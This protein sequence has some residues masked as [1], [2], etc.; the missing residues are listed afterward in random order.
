MVSTR[1]LDPDEHVYANWV[2]DLIQQVGK[3]L[4]RCLSQLLK[5]AKSKVR[6]RWA[7]RKNKPSFVQLPPWQYRRRTPSPKL[8]GHNYHQVSEISSHQETKSP[9]SSNI[10]CRP[11][12]N[13]SSESMPQIN[14]LP[15][16]Y[17]TN[18]D[19]PTPPATDDGLSTR[20]N[21]SIT[22]YGGHLPP[23]NSFKVASCSN[24]LK[25]TSRTGRPRG[26]L[27]NIPEEPI[28]ASLS[29]GTEIPGLLL[30]AQ[31]TQVQRVGH[32]DELWFT[33][34]PAETPGSLLVSSSSSSRQ[35]EVFAPSTWLSPSLHVH[36]Q[37]SEGDPPHLSAIAPIR[38]LRPSRSRRL[39]FPP[40]IPSLY[41]RAG[42]PFA[43]G[44]FPW[45]QNE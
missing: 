26:P 13:K 31:G 10:Y 18:P 29:A 3:A 44:N 33:T 5:E 22:K 34:I 6:A 12:V 41:F 39:S 32:I 25:K 9:D 37:S 8:C 16:L 21:I 40:R 35:D 28:P 19:P 23:S 7:R 4:R 17:V 11:Q 24:R 30:S 20:S 42:S 36:P 27:E 38:S 45:D 15:R 1:D 2:S 43:D 14:P